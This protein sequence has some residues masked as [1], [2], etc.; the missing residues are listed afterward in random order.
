M[1]ILLTGTGNLLEGSAV[2][3]PLKPHTLEHTDL[4]MWT[5]VFMSPDDLDPKTDM[6]VWV[7][8]LEEL[9]ARSA[10]FKCNDAGSGSDSVESEIT[11]QL[12]PLRTFLGVSRKTRV[13]VAWSWNEAYSSI[14]YSRSVPFLERA[15]RIWES[16]LRELQADHENLF[17]L[18]LRP[19]FAREG[20]A[21]CYDVRNYYVGYCRFSFK[22]LKMIADVISNL[23]YR[24]EQAPKKVLVLDCDNTLWGGVIGE[25]GLQGI[26]LGEDGVGRAYKDFQKG[27][28]ELAEQGILV[29][30]SSKNNE[31]DVWEVFDKH[32][33]MLLKRS[34]IVAHRINWQEKA[35]GIQEI[36]EELGL[37][38][39]SFVF[40]DDNHLEREKVRV[41][42]PEVTVP[43]VSDE[44][45]D[46]YTTLLGMKEFH[47]FV[48]TEEDRKKVSQYRSRAMF[49]TEKKTATD[50]SG[51]MRSLELEP[52]L[53]PISPPLLARCEQLCVKTNQF[54]LSLRRYDAATISKLSADPDCLVYLGHMKDRFGDH[55]N[56]SLVIVREYA[57][58][59]LAFIDTFLMSCR[60]LGRHFEAWLLEQLRRM[61]VTKAIRY[62]V[63]EYIPAARNQM[64]LDFFRAYGFSEVNG[65]AEI[66]GKPLRELKTTPESRLYQL[67][68]EIAKIPNLEHFRDE[69]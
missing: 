9:I 43:D 22:G 18:P 25:D 19:H 67:D 53:L 10:S 35:N 48:V 55:G 54:N 5:R 38:I 7:V 11:L 61:V 51:F 31:D 29:A 28:R 21:K 68:L 12:N 40:W 60:I 65:D 24:F 2:W 50:L 32:P 47:K 26:V 52:S 34:D 6:I 27:I 46:W 20:L 30:L 57:E 63:A 33:E 17:L 37:G 4:N 3:S 41:V 15:D 16:Q 59:K 66:N 64:V 49:H 36:A 69:D 58:N 23:V 45:F 56:V 44:V 13:V 39:D 14:Q 1:N 62:L 42:L 8:S